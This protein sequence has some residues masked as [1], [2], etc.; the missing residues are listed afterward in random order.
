MPSIHSLN[1]SGSDI[2][3]PQPNA[4]AVDGNAECDDPF[5]RAIR[6]WHL[7]AGRVADGIACSVR[8]TRALTF[9]SRER[10]VEAPFVSLLS[11]VR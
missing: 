10:Y 7:R 9:Q 3:E 5:A 2:A 8:P 1:A 6:L 11:S 4:R